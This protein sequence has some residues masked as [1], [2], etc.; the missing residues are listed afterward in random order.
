MSRDKL[1]AKCP[2]CGESEFCRLPSP[3]PHSMTTA[4]R[5]VSE[6]LAKAQCMRCGILQRV[7][8]R[9]L[10][11]T[12]FYERQYS[13]YERPGASVFDAPR[14]AAMA[15]W[16]ADAIAPLTP[17]TAFDAGCGRGW[18]L[19]A[20]SKR[21]PTTIFTGVEPSEQE[22]ENARSRGLKVMTGRVGPSLSLEASYDL[23]YS[24]NV[25]EHTTDPVQFMVTLGSLAANTGFIVIL[26]P[27]SSVPN[28]EFMFSDQNYS[29][30]PLQ[31]ASLAYC[32]GLSVVSWSTRPVVPG[33][34]DKQLMVFVKTGSGNMLQAKLGDD[35]SREDLFETRSRYVQS[36][37][38]C[39]EYL[40][41]RTCTAKR[42]LNFGTS[43]WSMLLAAYCPGY[44]GLV[45]NCVIDGGNGEFVGKQVLD[46]NKI[47][48]K[49]SD[50]VVLG[51]NPVTQDEFAERFSNQG[52]PCVRWDHIIAR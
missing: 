4:G 3:W 12:D 14:Y 47:T 43:T 25:V 31:L 11:E 26:C 34:C 9:Q 30:T 41:T 32:A 40:I 51:I 52:M 19:E 13:F 27:D 42:V 22:S 5:I 7:E 49:N 36:Y 6:P 33:L 39:D 38:K 35:L 17:R 45:D 8:I 20:L 28:A 2:L 18:M 37:A 46:A 21:F 48:L 23:V 10:G 29:F 1:L 24:T 16:I 44:W 15:D 50:A